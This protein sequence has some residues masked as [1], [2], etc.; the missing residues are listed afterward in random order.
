[1]KRDTTLIGLLIL[2]IL[3]SHLNVSQQNNSWS[4]LEMEPC[5]VIP[6]CNIFLHRSSN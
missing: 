6:G 5:S 4:S 1:M 3:K 2:F